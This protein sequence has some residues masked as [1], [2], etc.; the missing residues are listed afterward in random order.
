VPG[1]GTGINDTHW[2]AVGVHVPVTGF[3]AD[4]IYLVGWYSIA[5]GGE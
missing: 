4:G 3:S 2:F 1:V 5:F